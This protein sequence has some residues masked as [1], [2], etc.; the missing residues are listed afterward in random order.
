LCAERSKFLGI[1]EIH[2]QGKRISVRD[3]ASAHLALLDHVRALGGREED[4]VRLGSA[5][6]SWRGAVY[7]AVVFASE[8]DLRLRRSEASENFWRPSSEITPLP[9]AHVLI[10]SRREALD[11]MPVA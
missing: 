1:Y 2:L 3:A 4:V 8:S 6:L 10:W 11:H 5:S 9:S 7:T